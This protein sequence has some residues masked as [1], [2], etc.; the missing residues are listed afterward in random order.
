M[1]ESRNTDV[2]KSIDS[3]SSAASSFKEDVHSTGNPLSSADE[4]AEA[5]K[6]NEDISHSDAALS[7]AT[8]DSSLGK[9]TNGPPVVSS[10]TQPVIETI[11]AASLE[12]QGVQMAKFSDD[13][14]VENNDVYKKSEGSVSV[15]TS[16]VLGVTQSLDISKAVINDMPQQPEDGVSVNIADR[17]S[18][19]Y[20]ISDEIKTTQ[21]DQK[22]EISPANK[23][24]EI[25]EV[26]GDIEDVN[27]STDLADPDVDATK[28]GSAP[29]GTLHSTETSK[30]V[31]HANVS[32]GLIDTAAPFES[33]KEAVSKFGGI[34]DWKAHKSLILERRKH[35]Q[36]ELERTQEDIPVYKKQSEAAESEKVQV[37]KELDNT[38]RLV[39]ELK[40]SLEKSQMEE[41]QARQDSELAQLRAKEM[42]QGITDEVS[43]AAKAQLEVAK[44]RHAAAVAELKSVKEE[45]EAVRGEYVSLV[46]ERDMAIKRAEEAASAS[47]DVEKTVEDLTLELI[48]ARESLESAHAA[49]LE[50]E[51]HRI[52][53][54]L[55][56][57]QDIFN[58]EKELKH[59][60]EEVQQLNEQ[61]S[62]SRD[63]KSKLDTASNLL[64]TLKGEL[65]A[66]MEAKLNQESEIVEEG[67]VT[68]NTVE[69]KGTHTSI[70]ASIASVK[71][72]LEE[73]NSSI[74]KAK[75]EV[76]CLRVAAMSLKA[77]LEKEKATLAPMRQREGMASITV[78]SLE[79]ELDRI[80]SEIELAQ[81]KE[82]EAREQMVELP[83]ALQ[84][85]AQEADET[86][87]VAHL[88]QEELRK[89]KEEA[90]Q[91]KDS[92]STMEIRLHAAL[93]EIEAAEA[94]EKLALA[95]VKA[96]QESEQAVSTGTDL[97]SGGVTLPLEE[98]YILSKRAHEAEESAS[99]RVAAAISQIE[100]AKEAESRSLENLEAAN[101]DL[102]ES[103]EALRIA[104]EKA[105][106]AKE[107]KL[108]AEQELRL[109]RA[110]HEQRRKAGDATR[111]AANPTRS[112]PRSF[113]EHREQ[114]IPDQEQETAVQRRMPPAPT[115]HSPESDADTAP[116][117]AKT[118]KKKSLFP[119]LVTFLAR[120]KGQSLK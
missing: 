12:V 30:N 85:A 113:E 68:D 80:K 33:V 82:K 20:R 52:G 89:A 37:L 47:K 5:N 27:M 57:D 45:L 69:I 119:R 61:L 70:Q 112:P 51:E 115:V 99:E 97:S 120:K 1:E 102:T 93:K 65:T 31:K 11:V 60:E 79:A 48:T 104:T 92:A 17:K 81:T 107:G 4:K 67:N 62:Q 87:S 94:S 46:K 114:K 10:E 59:A 76:N 44:A 116:S 50:A 42:E 100:V 109:W 98:Y 6:Q 40:L 21:S 22:R 8:D 39:E 14:M 95:A 73:V 75:D 71:E 64:L 72:E 117:E 55:A 88:A 36:M 24:P 26:S 66:Y 58:W 23:G 13:S 28:D 86:K 15:V 56:R 54:A 106:K 34:V 32:R 18:G 91:A 49:H 90:E 96:L 41:V 108:A 2:K 19:N 38:K 101:K 43:V 53:A 83:K 3:S 111:V 29:K 84:Q 63:L 118:R 110:E 74:E 103:K 78:S 35:V 9:E 16:D 7:Q 105:E 25:T 77:E